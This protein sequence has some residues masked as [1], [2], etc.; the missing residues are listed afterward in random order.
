MAIQEEQQRQLVRDLLR[1]VVVRKWSTEKLFDEFFNGWTNV[2]NARKVL[3]ERGY[4]F[5]DSPG[6]SMVKGYKPSKS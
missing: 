6:T 3:E 2:Y 1:I 4:L 5:L